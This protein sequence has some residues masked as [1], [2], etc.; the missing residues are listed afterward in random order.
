MIISTSV[1]KE[2]YY[3]K[4]IRYSAN[5]FIYLFGVCWQNF[6]SPIIHVHRWNIN[7]WS[8][9]EI[10]LLQEKRKIM[11]LTAVKWRWSTNW[12]HQDATLEFHR[13]QQGYTTVLSST[14]TKPDTETRTLFVLY[15]FS[16]T[17][18]C[19]SVDARAP[20]QPCAAHICPCIHRETDRAGDDGGLCRLSGAD[21][22]DY[23]DSGQFSGGR[24]L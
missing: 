14:V 2:S 1:L 18:V 21:R 13:D 11:D 23:G 7:I 24:D 6:T 8:G 20:Q 3:S 4:L 12:R 10:I 16:H 17:S 15:A 19:C 22:L 5:I 9:Y